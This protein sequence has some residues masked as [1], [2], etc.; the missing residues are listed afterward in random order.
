MNTAF[1]HIAKFRRAVAGERQC[2]PCETAYL[3]L[4]VQPIDQEIEGVVGTDNFANIAGDSIQITFYP[5][6]MD[7]HP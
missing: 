3:G 6:I 7:L 2:N 1:D 4:M 5:F